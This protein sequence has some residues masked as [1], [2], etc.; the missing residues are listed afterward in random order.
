MP[1]T[2]DA[3]GL[4]G[5]VKITPRRFDDDRGWFYES[6]RHS[7]FADAGI[8]VAFVQD[9]HSCSAAGTLRGL[10]YQVDPYAQ[11]KLV[12]VVS[13]RVYDVVVDI[14]PNSPTFGR[15][16]GM[17]ISAQGGEMLWIASGFAHGFLALEDNTQLVYKCTAE[18]HKNSERSIRWNDPVIGIDWP[19]LPDA[20]YLLSPK[21]ADA[22]FL[23][24]AE[25][26]A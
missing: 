22:P 8:D 9:N 25:V 19:V 16:F 7:E 3:T 1:F 12:R 15:W 26:F 23:Q 20:P 14:S 6:Y 4:D 10:H 2:F 13:G 21:D 11:G 17:D 5:V 24:D 18:Y